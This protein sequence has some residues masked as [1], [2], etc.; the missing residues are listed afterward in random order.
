VE[1]HGF[2]KRIW[3]KHWLIGTQTVTGIL[4]GYDALMNLVLDD[5][6]EVLRGMSFK[7]QLSNSD[8]C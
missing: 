4:K 3:G 1:G 7:Y 8:R 5:V 2:W 6:E